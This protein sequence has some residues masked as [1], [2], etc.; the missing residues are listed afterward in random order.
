MKSPETFNGIVAY[1]ESHLTEEI[2]INTL[3]AQASLS[4]YEFR[5]IFSFVAGIGINEYIRRRRMSAAAERLLGGKTSI[6]KLSVEY[7]YDSPSSF[8]R[9]FR[10]FH[11]ISPSEVGKEGSAVRMFTKLA[12]SLGVFGGEELSYSVEESEGFYISGIKGLSDPD[13]TECCEKVWEVFN[14]SPLS[15]RKELFGGKIYAAY[16][17]GQNGPL[18][19]IG[20]RTSVRP[21]GTAYIAIPPARWACFPL[22]TTEDSAVNAFYDRILFHWLSSSGQKRRTELPNLEI[23]PYNMENDGFTWEI[24]I[25]VV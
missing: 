16:E 25:P 14:E 10:D 22:H 23:F 2:D 17:N 24:R 18:C 9:A 6:T 12:F 21:E 8:A 11:G 19:T 4:V 20:A 5:R 7:G 1:I 13:D 3:A 15:G